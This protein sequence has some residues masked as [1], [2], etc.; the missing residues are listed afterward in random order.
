[1]TG[2]KVLD[3]W[4]FEILSDDP[5]REVTLTWTGPEEVLGMSLLIDL[6]TGEIIEPDSRGAYTFQMG[7]QIRYFAWEYEKRPGKKKKK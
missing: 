5:A 6:D 2:K 3:E 7:A 1:M 4:S